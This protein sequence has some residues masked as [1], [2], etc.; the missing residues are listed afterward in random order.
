MCLAAFFFL[1]NRLDF[2]T[3]GMITEGKVTGIILQGSKIIPLISY[4]AGNTKFSISEETNL[5]LEPGEHIK[6]IYRK[7]CP[8]DARVYSFFGF[9]FPVLAWLIA[10][11]MLLGAA[12]F[13][14]IDE[15]QKIV[16]RFGKKRKTQE[17]RELEG[18]DNR[19]SAL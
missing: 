19:D 12:L 9:W 15:N 11:V 16:I 3:E 1:F 17:Y 8:E 4:S 18:K 2:I 13:S 10:P 6:I 7:S 5:T 14:F